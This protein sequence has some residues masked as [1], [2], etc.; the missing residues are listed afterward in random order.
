MRPKPRLSFRKAAVS[1]LALACVAGCNGANAFDNKD[2]AASR[3]KPENG[4][5]VA[6]PNDFSHV[7]VP[8][9]D[10]PL[11]VPLAMTVAVMRKPDPKADTLGYLRVGARVARS[12][13]PVANEG[14]P[15]GWYAV[16]P[17]GFV[18][19][20]LNAT[21]KLD[22]PLARAIQVEPDRSKPMPYKYAFLRS[23]APN[24]MRVPSKA[25]QFA[26]PDFP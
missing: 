9:A 3:L 20:G 26:P 23:I 21:L 15:D 13:K 6:D 4:G 12:E 11:L 14:C 25:E 24:Y 17:A 18:C 10:G 2:P 16:R 1:V 22:H 8:P 7:P 5:I 19:A